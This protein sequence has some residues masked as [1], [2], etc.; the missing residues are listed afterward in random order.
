MFLRLSKD[1]P[2]GT[3]TKQY[4][5]TAANGATTNNAGLADLTLWPRINY[6]VTHSPGTNIQF[7]IRSAA[8]SLGGQVHDE[9][10]QHSGIELYGA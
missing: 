10:G 2:V 5:V 6:V 4:T 3:S 8:V 7:A 9:M 1:A